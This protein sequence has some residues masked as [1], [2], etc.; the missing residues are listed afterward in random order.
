MN[1]GLSLLLMLCVQGQTNVLKHDD[2]RKLLQTVAGDRLE[3][4]SQ[5]TVP[6]AARSYIEGRHLAARDQHGAALAHFRNAAE[7]HPQ[8]SAPWIGMAI[9]LAAIGKQS[10]AMAAWHEVLLRDPNNSQA[11]L[12]VGLDEARRRNYES[13][14]KMLSRSWL[15]HEVMPEESLLRYAAL[16]AS[17]SHLSFDALVEAM[18]GYEKAMIEQAFGSLIQ[19]SAGEMWRSVIQQLVD[20]QAYSIAL[21]LTRK[22][23]LSTTHQLKGFLLTALPVLEAVAQGDAQVTIKIYNKAMESDGLPLGP[24]WYEPVS[25]AEGYSMAAQSMSMIGDR[26]GTINLYRASMAIF[27]EDALVLNNL[28]WALLNT[29]GP[30]IEVEELSLKAYELDADAPYIL[31]TLGWFYF[32]KGEMTKALDFLVRALRGSSQP[33][34]ELYEHMGDAYWQSGQIEPAIRAWSHGLSI[35]HSDDFKQNLI[36]GFATLNY[37]VWGIAVASPEKLYDLEM[38]EVYERLTKKLL[39]AQQTHSTD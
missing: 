4:P 12:I 24:K 9:S 39:K 6:T 13:A 38:G 34:P 30:T 2:F 33:S 37:S 20:V 22:G 27:S 18:G 21:D 29:D 23:I 26:Q 16:R 15:D 36:E 11:L 31:D 35:M 8:A 19:K 32:Q 25:L 17:A 5:V 3:N 7:L 1:L 14:T 10:A 28:A